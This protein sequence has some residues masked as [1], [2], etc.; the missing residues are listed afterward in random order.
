[1]TREETATEYNELIVYSLK[2]AIRKLEKKN[3]YN[4]RKGLVH[5]ITEFRKDKIKKLAILV[6]AFTL[7]K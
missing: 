3:A 1:M 5:Y 4:E 6:D 7:E 2:V